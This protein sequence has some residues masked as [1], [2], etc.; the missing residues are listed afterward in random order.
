[1]KRKY[2]MFP[3]FIRFKIYSRYQN[4]LVKIIFWFIILNLP[5]TKDYI[6]MVTRGV[7]KWLSPVPLSCNPMDYTPPGSS[8]QGICKVR[9]LEWVAISFT[10]GSSWSRD[11]TLISCIGSQILYHWAT[12]EALRWRE[13]Q[14]NTYQTFGQQK[15]GNRKQWF[16][17]LKR[18]KGKHCKPRILYPAIFS[19]NESKIEI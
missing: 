3:G 11:W 14:I 17:I 19:K 18:L 2:L 4:E 6:L 10:R 7:T 5:N 1:M 9:I 12:R 16:K 13:T 15:I 8:V